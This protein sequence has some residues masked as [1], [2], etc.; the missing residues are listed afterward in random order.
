M[1]VGA[2][3]I[4][5]RLTPVGGRVV[6]SL[7]VAA[8]GLDAG[9]PL[10][11]I[12]PG[13]GLPFYTLPTARSL[14]ARGLDC[15]VLDLPGFG[16]ARPRP[17]RPNIHAIG[18][19]AA[20]WV[21]ARAAERPVVVLGHSTGSQAA[22]TA[23][24][25]LEGVRHGYSLVMAGP[26]FA[27][28]RRHVVPLAAV[29]PFAYRDD[30]PR[31]VDPAEIGHGRLGIAQMLHSGMRDAP[32]RRIAALRAPLTVTSGVHDAFAPAAWLD[33]L[34][35]SAVSAAR[36]RTSLLGGSHNNLFTHPDELAD[37]VCLAASDALSWT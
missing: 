1:G 33:T 29:T 6:R 18:L 34:A 17:T 4:R 25:A 7:R 8:S 26:T 16:S 32:E 10:V 23:A 15:E 20:G 30:G 37:L 5:E 14:T 36:T 13:L 35:T 3:D 12:L 24:L 11:V 22:L 9:G 21:R 27:P 28:T 2:G 31:E 19:S